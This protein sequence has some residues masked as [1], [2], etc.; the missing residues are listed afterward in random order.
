MQGVIQA[1]RV[2]PSTVEQVRRVKLLLKML[3]LWSCFLTLSLVAASGSTFF[4]EEAISL[5]D[6]N[7]R[8]IIFFANLQRF[9]EF[10]VSVIA[11]SVIGKLKRYNEQKMELVRIGIG[12]SCCVLC[13]ITA[14]ATAARRQHELEIGDGMSV[15]WLTPRYLLL[16]LMG[17]LSQ[18]GLQLFYKSQVFEGLFIFGPPF[19]EL[20]MGVGKY[21]SIVCILIFSSERFEWFAKELDNSH[22]DRYYIFL[23]VLSFGNVVIYCLVARWYGDDAFLLED[24]EEM[25]IVHQ[26]VVELEGQQVY[27]PSLTQRTLSKPRDESC[28]DDIAE[29]SGSGQEAETPEDPLLGSSESTKNIS[30]YNYVLLRAVTV[31]SRLSSRAARRLRLKNQ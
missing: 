9:T 19:V 25:G 28:G 5:N 27:H 13:C 12:M 10:A 8:N 29:S 21:L 18:D 2:S 7:I 20:M 16:G 31:F 22:L 24:E 11:N 14:W 17:G 1:G 30:T 6:N 15:Y 4:F 26:L 23:A 3:P